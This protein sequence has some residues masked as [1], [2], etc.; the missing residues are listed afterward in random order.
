[1]PAPLPPPLLGKKCRTNLHPYG[2][3]EG[4]AAS[5]A[6]WETAKFHRCSHA[7]T[8]GCSRNRRQ[9]AGI[10]ETSAQQTCRAGRRDISS[11][12]GDPSR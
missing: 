4:A 7:A 5:R 12:K 9:S 10:P 2:S 11:R 1:M 6:G 3:A 8:A